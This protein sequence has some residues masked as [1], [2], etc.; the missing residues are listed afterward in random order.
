MRRSETEWNEND[1]AEYFANRLEKV[2]LDNECLGK[3]PKFET[4]YLFWLISS[5]YSADL[6]TQDAEEITENGEKGKI[7]ARKICL[8]F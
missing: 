5:S 1:Q 3:L 4:E 6:S 2:H 8:N 7:F